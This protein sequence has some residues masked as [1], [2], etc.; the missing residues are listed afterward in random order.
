MN[1]RDLIPW[2]RSGT[3]QS[4]RGEDVHPMLALHR[5]MNRLFD[6]FTRGFESRL[7]MFGGAGWPRTD[8]VET[9]NEYRVTAELPG[10]EEKDVEV[11]L[12]GDLLTIKG[13]KK[14]ESGDGDAV[15]SER[16][17]GK[18]QRSMQLGGEVDRDKVSASFQNGVLTV[19]LP[20]SAEAESKAKRIPI[21]TQ[22]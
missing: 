4:Y 13:E 22:H 18:F 12:E 9:D 1:V 17:H 19:T 3:P 20:K 8:V 10:L 11:T 14:V 15:V 16:Y 6:D 5:E 7:P 21:G 2:G